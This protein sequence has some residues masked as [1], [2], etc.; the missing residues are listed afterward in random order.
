MKKRRLRAPSPALVVSLIALFV[1][2]GGTSYAAINLPKNSVGTKQLKNGAVTKTKI[3]KKTITQL[4]GKPGPAGPAGP[5]GAT[6]PQGPQGAQGPPGTLADGAVT[7][8]KIADGAVSA[9]KLA[10]IVVV[11]A[12]S[13]SV[14]NG[15]AVGV[16]ATCPAGSRVIS[17][18]FDPGGNAVPWRVQRSHLDG[19]GWRAFG[20][21]QTGVNSFIRAEAYCL[22]G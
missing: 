21:N 7:S 16:T 10:T 3:N 2:L 5:T 19:N 17:G 8:A 11:T 4:M 12:D 22:V 9:S 18:G 15:A 14:A 13:T 6:G 20:T 1:A